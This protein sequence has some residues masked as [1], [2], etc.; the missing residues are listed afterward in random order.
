[1]NII[2]KI[3]LLL[4]IVFSYCQSVTAQEPKMLKVT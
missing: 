3:A 1:M 4:A 2:R